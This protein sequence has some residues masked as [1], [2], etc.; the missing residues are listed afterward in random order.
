MKISKITATLSAVLAWA[1]FIPAASACI[2]GPAQ[3]SVALRELL[4]DAQKPLSLATLAQLA[5]DL[6]KESNPT[7]PSIVGMWSFQFISQG[8]TTRTP[9]IA[10]GTM[11]N[12]GYT[13][14][15]SDGTEFFT[16]GVRSPAQGNYCLGVWEPTG[17]LTLQVNH[18]A[19]NYDAATGTLLGTIVIVE[20]ITLSPGGTQYSGTFTETVFDTKGNKTDSLT[21]QVTAQRVT[22]DRI[23]P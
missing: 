4:P 19:L 9:P 7:G 22:V 16:S 21:G 5:R 10:D 20:K 8:N 6:S 18:F 1:M 15:H 3:P 2:S 14:W 12:F 11:I 13:Q 23:T 17:L